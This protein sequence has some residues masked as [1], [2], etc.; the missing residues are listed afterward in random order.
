MPRP[1][2]VAMPLRTQFPS[3]MNL[4]S[5]DDAFTCHTR[6]RCTIAGAR[7]S[8]PDHQARRRAPCARRGFTRSVYTFF[9]VCVQL[10]F[11]RLATPKSSNL[12]CP[13]PISTVLRW[14]ERAASGAWL[15][16][17]TKERFPRS[18]R[19]EIRHRTSPK[20]RA[21]VGPRPCE[22]G[23]STHDPPAWLQQTYRADGDYPAEREQEKGGDRTAKKIHTGIARLE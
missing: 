18:Q 23:R 3:D 10:F 8:G 15:E 9:P 20:G 7:P 17:R 1:G 12:A 11:L 5:H 22:G 6:E 13:G 2:R 16:P 19:A 14:R 21:R 4:L